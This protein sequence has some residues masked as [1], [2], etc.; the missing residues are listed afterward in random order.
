MT[1]ISITPATQNDTPIIEEILLDAVNWLD[2]TGKP[3]WRKDQITWE[4]LSKDFAASD[5]QIAYVDGKP[6]GCMAVIDYDPIVWPHIE[7][8][9][10]LFIHKLAVK[11]F[12]AG[13]GIS[14]A[15]IAYAKTMCVDRE[16]AHLRLDCDLGRASLRALYESNGFTCVG[17]KLV[18][19]IYDIALYECKVNDTRHLYHYFESSGAPFRTLTSLPR[20]EAGRV[21]RAGLTE[22]TMFDVE[23]FLT[24]RYDRDARLRELFTQ[25]GGRPRRIAPVYFTLGPNEGMKT[26]FDNPAWIKIPISDFDPLTLSFT[27]GDSFAA[28]DPALNTGEEWWGR[29]FD[30][31]GIMRLI[32]KYGWP[33]DPPYDM[34]NR[35]FPKDRPIN[36][37]LKF[38]E[39]HVWGYDGLLDRY[40]VSAE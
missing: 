6:A 33:E 38:V 21:I 11:R 18:Y 12:A 30:Y 15:L 32:T 2:A 14:S 39:A 7:K 37:C 34:K 23:A 5:F 1:T 4:R 24:R 8:G 10:S 9:K 31:P 27:Y 22:Q 16:L 3:L 25:I 36:Q 29:V 19:E 20:E 35:V 26:W 13:Q 28:L 17:A 40:R